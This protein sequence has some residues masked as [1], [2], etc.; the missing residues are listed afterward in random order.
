[1]DGLA[2]LRGKWV[3]AD[4]KRLKATLDKFKTAERLA[5]MDDLPFARAQAMRLL[6]GGNFGGELA[7]LG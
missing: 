2:L 4:Q 1:M 3:E 7:T 5:G 6:A